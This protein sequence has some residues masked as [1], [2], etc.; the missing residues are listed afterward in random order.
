MA[1]REEAARAEREEQ[2][3][4]DAARFEA[5]LTRLAPMSLQPSGAA[6]SPAAP[7]GPP[8]APPTPKAAVQP[9]PPLSSDVTYQQFREWRR[10]WEDYATMVDIAS[11]SRPKQLIQLRMCLSLE[12]Q[13][14]LE[15]TL[16]VPPSST[17]SVDEVLDVLQKHIKE[18]SN[19]ALRRRAFTT[20]KQATGESFADFFV[21]LKSLSEEIDVCKAHSTECKEAWLKHGILTGVQDEE[22]VQRIIALDAAATL[23]DVVTLC[24]SYEATRTAA[25]ALRAPPGVRAVSQY[26]KDKKTDHRTK[27]DARPAVPTLQSSC[28]NCGKQQH[29]PKGCPATEAVCHGCGKTGHWSHM[30]KCPAKTVQCNACSRYGH[31]EKLCKSSNPKSQHSSKPKL[32]KTKKN[33]RATIHVVRTQSPLSRVPETSKQEASNVRRVHSTV[34]VKPTPSPT[35]CI[36]VTHGE[37]SNTMEM[38]PDTGADTTVIGPQH[39]QHLGLTSRNLQP[40]PSL[41]YYNA[42]GSKMPAALGSLQAELT[43]GKLSCSGWIDVQGA[44]STPLL[45]W[46]HCRELGIIP[47]DFPRQITDDVST[48]GRIRESTSAT[49]VA[50]VQCHRQPASVV[51]PLPAPSPSLPLHANTSLAEAKEYFLQEYADVLVKKDD[52]Q[53]APLQPMSGSPMRIHLREDA[54]P[55][56]VHTPRLIPRAYQDHVKAELDSMVAQGIIAPADEDPSPWCHPMVVVPKVG[57]GVRI[58]TDLSKLNSQVSR[59]AHPSPTPFAAIRSVDPEAKYFTTIDA[60]CGYWQI[61]LAEEDQ[62]LTTFITPYGRFRYLRGPMGFAATGDAFCRRGDQA[63]Q[64]VMQCVK[65]VDDLLLYDKDYL[66][67]LH[68]VN[69]VLARCRSHGITLNAEKFVLAAE[70]VSYCGYQLSHDG[71][72]A[73]PGKVRAITDFVKPANLTDLRSFM[74]LAN[75]LADFSPDVSAAAAPLRPLMSPK[76]AFVWT[77]DHDQA[78]ERVKKALS[79]PPV[80]AAF[81]PDLPTALQT[82]ASRLYGL[83]YALLQDHGGGH[84]RLV[85]CGSRFLTDTETRYATIELELLAVVWA[86][87]KCK[88]YL[89]GLQHFTLVTD[90]RPLVPILNSYT[91]D[92]IENPRLQRLKEKLAAFVFTATWRPGKELCIPDALSRFPV[93]NP[94]IDDDAL[95]AETSFS[96]RSIVTLGAVES[97]ATTATD[98]DPAMEELRRAAHEDPAYVE[99]LQHIKQGFPSDRYAL[100]NTLRPYWKLREDLYCEEDLVLYGARV[101]VPAA[102]RHRVLARL[103]DSHRGAEATKRRARQAVYWPGIDADIVNTVRACEPCQVMQPSQ[104]REPHLCDDN[105]TRPFE[106][107]SADFFSTAGKYF[108]VVADRLSGWPVVVSCGVDTTSSATIRHLR[109]LFRDLGVPVRLRTDGGPQFA[110][111]EFAAFLERWGIRHN[112]ST[113]HYPQSNGH[114]E[115]AVKSVKY[116]IQKVAPTGHL[117]CEAFDRGLLELR[118]TPNH[119]GRSPAQIL[120]GHPLRSCVPA[121]AKAF[122]KQWQARAESCDRRAAVRLQ[123]DTDRYDAHARPLPPLELDAVVRVQDPTTK[124]WDKVGTVMGI[125]K[126]RD[127]LVKMPSGRIW[128]RNRRFLRPSMSPSKDLPP[129]DA[130]P[131]GAESPQ[132]ALPRRSARIKGRRDAQDTACYEREGG[133][134]M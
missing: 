128:W 127:Y 72:A 5:L 91:L 83:G 78:F 29:G 52:L 63:L 89:T 26:R 122:Q 56:A 115:A 130:T 113:P 14:V 27:A 28:S 68:R 6:G 34:R 100:P 105:P 41:D 75:Q 118:N 66:P 12:T 38:I 4:E 57:G 114:A 64:G 129:T 50:T 77:P 42:D 59:P 49:P 126:S 35:I 88:F 86:M 120:Y 103:H 7:S 71:I 1:D 16:Q 106:S 82:D 47:K 119:T 18:S 32:Q 98:S 125:G 39:L 74:G 84:F 124:R 102:L 22:V 111:Q 73:D 85:Q 97:L 31:F 90:H 104:Q 94:T 20:C 112:M 131:P 45:S 65:V 61:P 9:P 48:V 81:D 53:K 58:T 99:L 101:V 93:S 8:A 121:H 76:R 24:R 23:A 95:D 109:Q 51:A 60:L 25:S 107:V 92:A 117:D 55:F 70:V 36:V 37:R 2:R 133:R 116:L 46:Q 67:H 11:L 43:Y 96:V 13:R 69:D 79:N 87:K 54:K 110:S 21:R 134:E 10:K 19:E 108:L 62:Q 132:P 80:L 17:S 3:R 30:E 33:S 15:H 40:P 44:L 123:D